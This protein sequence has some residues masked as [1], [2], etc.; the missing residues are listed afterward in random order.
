VRRVIAA[1]TWLAVA[2]SAASLAAGCG[3]EGGGDASATEWA[4]GVCS[5]ITTWRTSVASAADS[6]R[7]GDLSEKG[8]EDAFDDFESATDDF[9]DDLQGLGRPETEAGT[10][11]KDALDQLAD[12]VEDN[13]S[14]MKRAV[15]DISGV[16]GVL[17][18]V[19]V[20]G[21]GLS[22]L[23]D[24]VSAAFSKLEDLDAGGELE[25]AFRDASSCD[26]LAGS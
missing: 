13:V 2:L 4:D 23:G 19:T 5:A 26:E 6:L 21:A 1:G 8:I 16:S 12:D 15:D 14:Q 10:Q 22:R 25:R 9:V 3:D 17:E 11:A 24:Q 20:V 18:A 7:A